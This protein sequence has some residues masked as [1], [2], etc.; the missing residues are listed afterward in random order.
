MELSD[1]AI[2][3]QSCIECGACDDVC[4]VTE[5]IDKYYPSKK[6]KDAQEILDGRE[7]KEEQIDNIYAC[8]RCRACESVCKEDIQISE[9]VRLARKEIVK[10][11]REPSLHRKISENILNHGVS[12]HKDPSERLKWTERSFFKQNAEYVYM[13]GCFASMINTNIARS[14]VKILRE[15]GVDFTILGDREVCC[16]SFAWDNGKNEIVLENAKKN[17]SSIESVGSNKIISACAGCHIIYSRVY[18]YIIDWN[19]Q[20]MNI[21]EFIYNLIKDDKIKFKNEI[22]K[23]IVIHKACN[24]EEDIFSMASEIVG[25]IPGIKLV[26]LGMNRCCGAPSGVKPKFP[27]ISIEIGSKTIKDAKEKGAEIIVTT[28]PFCNF[29]FSDVKRNKGY[30]IEI[31]DLPELVTNAIG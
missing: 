13:T 21:I 9:I 24:I 10:L 26:E 28:C 27:E 5:I 4:P 14:T 12:I 8:M 20:E 3:L 30:N 25:E 31:L 2:T 7:L 29:Q 6:I 18:P 22:K 17:K 19:I 16:S 15:A 11:G 1:Y 23:T